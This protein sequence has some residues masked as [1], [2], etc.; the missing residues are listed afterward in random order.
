[1]LHS[2]L[3]VIV[4]TILVL[5]ATGCSSNSIQSDV[6][7]VSDAET[8]NPIFTFTSHS[9]DRTFLGMWDANFDLENLKVEL[10]PKRDVSVHYNVTSLIPNPQIDILSIDTQT[11]MVEVDITINNPSS[12]DAHDLRFIVMTD[13]VGHMLQNPDNWTDLYDQTGGL[14]VNPFIA[15][16]KEDPNRLF[17]GPSQ[18]SENMTIYLPGMNTNVTFA[19]DASVG[20]N[21]LEPYIIHDFHQEEPL[22]DEVGSSAYM[23]VYAFDWQGNITSVAIYCPQITGITLWNFDRDDLDPGHYTTYLINNTGASEGTYTAFLLAFSSDSGSF[24]LYHMVEIDVAAPPAELTYNWTKTWGNND[25]DYLHGIT[26]DSVGNII[27]T[28]YFS[29]A[30]DFDPGSGEYFLTSLGREDVFLSKLDSNGSIIWAKS[31]GGWHEENGD[32]VVVD[33]SYINVVTGINDNSITI[34]FVPTSP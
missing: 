1:M 29:D 18:H 25:F 12:I 5:V 16:A 7:S 8:N 2:K 15:Y 11:G 3:T 21:C 34:L 26:T 23:D 30:V 4:M 32:A 9:E 20:G 27:T 28:G 31:W 13:A 14:P 22:S 17:A 10:V 33:S 24:P 19:V 6:L